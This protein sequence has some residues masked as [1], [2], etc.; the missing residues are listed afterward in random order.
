MLQLYKAKE[1]KKFIVNS[2]EGKENQDE[3]D[4]EKKEEN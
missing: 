2:S 3:V 1:I 4:E